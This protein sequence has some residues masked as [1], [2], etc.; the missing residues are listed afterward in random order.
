[1][2]HREGRH[3]EIRL[4]DQH[5]VGAARV[6]HEGPR[7]APEAGRRDDLGAVV[8]DA[9][10]AVQLVGR[11]EPLDHALDPLRAIDRQRPRRGAARPMLQHQL[12]QVGDV[13][14]VE[15][16]QEHRLHLSRGELHQGQV[17]RAARAGVDHEQA[18]ARHDRR[19]RPGA[20]R[21]RHR[22]AGAAKAHVQSV[23]QGGERVGRQA[24]IV[25]PRHHVLG[26]LWARDPAADR[27]GRQQRQRQADEPAPPPGPARR[28]GLTL[29]II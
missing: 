23:G 5:H 13:V 3:L 2:P 21:V 15:V 4:V 10:A 14:G 1:V 8:G 20:G 22:R 18:M 6:G 12:A 19:A 9:V 25:G 27:E 29:T 16:G 17:A 26:E 28:P 11:L 24:P 7:L